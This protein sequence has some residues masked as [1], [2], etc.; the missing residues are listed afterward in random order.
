MDRAP[1][2]VI[3]APAGGD[4]TA[5][6]AQPSQ[7]LLRSTHELL[8]ATLDAVADAV[9]TFHYADDSIYCNK[10]FLELWGIPQDKAASLNRAAMNAYQVER[11]KDPQRLLADIEQRRKNPGGAHQSLIE[12]IDGR[13]FERSV[14]PQLL[15]G[16]CVGSVITYR[17]VTERLRYEEKMTFNQ[18]VLDNSAPMLWIDRASSQITFANPRACRHLG[19][20]TDEVMGMG[21]TDFSIDFTA[22]DLAALDKSLQER[23][24]PVTFESH[25][26]RKDG[27]IRNVEVTAFLAEST[28]RSVYIMSVR[29]TTA[30]KKAEQ[31]KQRE[32]ATLTSLINSI[33]DPVF[34]KDDEGRY[35][36][37]NEAYASLVGH[38][39][40]G[41]L[42]LT[43]VDLFP[44]NV[45]QAMQARDAALKASGEKHSS[46]DWITYPDGRCFLFETLVSLLRNEQG[47]PQGVLGVSRNIT[48]HKKAEEDNRKAKEAAEEATQMKSDFLANMSHEIRTP[49]N[50][51]IGLSHLVL[52]TE[53]TTRQRDYITK[54]QTS[55]Q[56]LLGV[57][58]D[59]L[60]FSKVEAGKLDLEN[61]AF[62]LEKLLDNTGSLISEKAHSKG[63][64][65]VFE[66]A[67]DVPPHLIGDSLRLGQ[68]LIN[69]ANNA[70]KFTEKGE[71]VISVRAS[72]HTE[73]DVLLHFR[74]RDTGI[75]LTQEQMG[76]LFQSFSQA[77]TSTTRKFGG[78]GLGLAISKQL[79]TLM[80]GEVGVE[81]DYGKGSTF[82]FSARLG[83]GTSKQRELVP[84][85]DLRGRRALVVDDNENARAVIIDMLE[86]MTFLVAEVSSGAAAIDEVARAAAA[87]TPY[88]IIYLDWRMPGM[89]G[90]ETARRIK[91]L[92]LASPPMF[93]MVTAHGR[94][95][96]LK[97]AEAIGIDN[98]LVKP[99]NSSILFDTT[100]NV[101]GERHEP[102]KE[103]E[104][105]V[106]EA[107]SRLEA[108]RGARILLVE[109][110]D[111]NQMVAREML[112]DIGLVVD[113]ADNGSIGLT[114]AQQSYYDL[115][116]MD[117]QMPVMDGVTATRELR[118]IARLDSLPI[119]AM[120]A[121]AMEQDRRK[122]MDA[123]MN[124]FLAKP[125][126][127]KDLWT[128]LLRW[129]RPAKARTAATAATAAPAS[130][131]PGPA[132]DG[133]PQGIAGLD[134][135]LGLS[136]MV[137]KKPLYLAM[138]RRYVTGQRTLGAQIREALATGDLATAE[139]LA[140]T[141]KGVSA[142][143][144]ATAVQD[145]AGA[146]EQA[147]RAG[148]PIDEL[149]T[150]LVELEVP[151]ANLLAALDEQ[152]PK[153]PATPH[154]PS[155]S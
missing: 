27:S 6:A 18:L 125:I 30:L 70:V 88:D 115:I 100:M 89:D 64:E 2:E 39:R 62:A 58:N 91:S 121:N 111:I 12:L 128:I 87:G 52:K 147:L 63:L 46:A 117:M 113:V 24:R 116:F 107:D 119:V 146:L 104:E 122:C 81:S 16:Q 9:L 10:R 148:R 48:D 23:K 3:S 67:P 102:A 45:A 5:E 149:Q 93:L 140:H 92:G 33:P 141:N 105:G 13:T 118:K 77:D 95:E 155:N 79:A 82:W 123:G 59:I 75:G 85:P 20:E 124:D 40:E 66:V 152:L 4:G 36:G 110:N 135:V 96:M 143:L 34:Y 72:E 99:V 8:A 21:V 37:C 7:G 68:I 131:R 50:A 114:M 14:A 103:T 17:D 84:K 56:H 51:I 31:D 112:E 120:T 25:H 19:Y 134:T 137:G 47:Q 138:L 90:M 29:D 53:L 15:Q 42:G 98:V 109:D 60:D 71:I 108:I 151:L 22:T 150:L 55:G 86:G 61:S 54:V 57:I 154:S 49:M 101:L 153:E 132:A 129:V 80:G 73:K 130:A 127:P 126:E 106:G 139:R 83:I 11:V 69:Y 144:G 145:L 26:R 94:E 1:T 32:Q 44:P 136:R 76:R 35:L 78:T 74:V 28:Q 97:E 43:C 133:L 38:T 142:N 41:I 65:L